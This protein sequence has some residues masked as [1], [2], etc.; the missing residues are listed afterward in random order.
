MKESGRVIH[1]RKELGS[2]IR[3]Q[4]TRIGRDVKFV[5]WELNIPPGLIKDMING[6]DTTLRP[7]LERVIRFLQFGRRHEKRLYGRLDIIFSKP[8]SEENFEESTPI[9]STGG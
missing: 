4:L 1:A 5:S 7:Q 6:V 9:F 3:D 8:Q 2:A